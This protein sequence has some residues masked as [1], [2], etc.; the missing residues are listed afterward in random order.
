MLIS[1]YESTLSLWLPQEYE[2]LQLKP[3]GKH[4]SSPSGH[5]SLLSLSLSQELLATCR[6]MYSTA[7]G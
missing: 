4:S 1:L 3:R 5:S 2:Q 7:E 6:Y